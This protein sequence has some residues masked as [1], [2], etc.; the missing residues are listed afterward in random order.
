MPF[1]MQV[2]AMLIPLKLRIKNASEANGK[3]IE[4]VITARDCRVGTAR[5]SGGSDPS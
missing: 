2:W 3:I 4:K 5:S 1:G